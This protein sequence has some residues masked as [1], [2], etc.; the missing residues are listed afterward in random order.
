MIS[1]RIIN[2]YFNWMYDM[3][4]INQSKTYYDLFQFLNQVEFVAIIPMDTNR[5]E[6]GRNFRYRFGYETGIPSYQITDSFGPT[7]CSVLEMMVALAHRCEEQIMRDTNYGDRTSIWFWGMIQTLGLDDMYDGNFDS[8][9]ASHVMYRFLNRTYEPN[10]RGGLFE[11][12]DGSRD[13]RQ[14]DIW[15]QM[16]FYLE[17]TEGE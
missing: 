17:E 1:N 16:C 14:I 12:H 7:P 3:V 9:R 2:D 5:S 11:I 10:G 15:Y 13:M 6:D 4:C 8:L